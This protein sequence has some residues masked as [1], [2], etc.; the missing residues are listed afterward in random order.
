MGFNLRSSS[1]YIVPCGP[2]QLIA[3]LARLQISMLPASF[4]QTISHSPSHSGR[5]TRHSRIAIRQCRT[6]LTWCASFVDYLIRWNEWITLPIR[7]CDLPL[8][9][10]ITFTVWDIAGPRAAMPVGGTTFRLFSKKWCVVASGFVLLYS[11]LIDSPCGWQ[12][13]EEGQAPNVVM[14]W[15]G[16]RWESGNHNAEQVGN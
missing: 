11:G 4:S 7:Y 14:A 3:Y 2:R 13:V 1:Y 15:K 8:S 10:Q 5:P 12:D 9:S 16:S 6:E